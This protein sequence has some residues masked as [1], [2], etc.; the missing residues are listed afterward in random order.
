MSVTTGFNKT[1]LV[2][3]TEMIP[4]DTG[5]CFTVFTQPTLHSRWLEI[6]FISHLDSKFLAF[7][8]LFKSYCP[9][10][11]VLYVITQSP[12][13]WALCSFCLTNKRYWLQELPA[14]SLGL[15]WVCQFKHCQLYLLCHIRSL[16]FMRTQWQMHH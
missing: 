7:I 9:L 15:I 11:M 8:F 6:Y 12:V 4:P 2:T 13:V 10:F 14:Y 5:H 1:T 3:R 16:H